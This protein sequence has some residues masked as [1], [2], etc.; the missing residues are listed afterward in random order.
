[1]TERRNKRSS[2]PVE[3]L[4]YLV[5]AVA[6]RSHAPAVVL[7]DEAGHIVAGMGGPGEVSGLA[8]AARDVAWGKSSADALDRTTSGKDVTARSIATRDGMLYVAALGDRMKAVGDAVRA[9]QRIVA[10][11]ASAPY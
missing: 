6:D 10:T 1:M 4:Q 7:V 9:V 8:R 2:D 11:A 3:A 5:E